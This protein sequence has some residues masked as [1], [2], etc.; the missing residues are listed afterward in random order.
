MLLS[1]AGAKPG[2]TVARGVPGPAGSTFARPAR[3]GSS[4]DE[5]GRLREICANVDAC[6]IRSRILALQ[7]CLD[8]RMCTY[9]FGR[10]HYSRDDSKPT[11]FVQSPYRR[12][13]RRLGMLRNDSH[14][15]HDSLS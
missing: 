13:I 6:Q 9:F 5:K 11:G 8:P 10:G 1:R 3:D 12:D 7:K 4:S 15:Q 14:R 2:S